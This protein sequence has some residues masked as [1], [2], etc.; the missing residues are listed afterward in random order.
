MGEH[1]YVCQD[2][3]PF[4]ESLDRRIRRLLSSSHMWGGLRRQLLQL[5]RALS[6]AA[7]A[8][9]SAAAGAAAG[10]V[11]AGWWIGGEAEAEAIRQAWLAVDHQVT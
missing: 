3:E 5:R 10:A 1:C 2:T 4:S 6:A 8:A 9:A 7:A 11:G